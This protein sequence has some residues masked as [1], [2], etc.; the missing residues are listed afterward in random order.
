MS[1]GFPDIRFPDIESN[2]GRERPVPAVCKI[3]CSNVLGLSG[4][5]YDLTVEL[6]H[7]IILLFSETLIFDMRLFGVSGSCRDL[8]SLSCC[9]GEGCLGPEVR[10]YTCE[11]AIELSPIPI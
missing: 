1:S 4:N 8:V 9:A 6:S 3:L 5:R 2:S 7:C 11:M 10:L